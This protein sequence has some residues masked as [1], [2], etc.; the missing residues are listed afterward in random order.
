MDEILR[1]LKRLKEE[2]GNTFLKKYNL[3]LTERLIIRLMSFSECGQCNEFLHEVENFIRELV[4]NPQLP[5]RKEYFLLI[6]KITGHLQE[7][8][9]LIVDGHYTSMYMVIG[10]ALGI[11]LGTVFSQSLG[12]AASMGVGMP[13]GL[14]IGIAVGSARDAKEKKNGRVI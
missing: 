13:I 1:E 10:M 4:R 11:A 5:A 9:Q 6:K 7:K 12:Q 14:V 8:H 2:Y 3:Q